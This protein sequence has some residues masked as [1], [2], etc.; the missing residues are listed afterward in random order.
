MEVSLCHP[1]IA[2]FAGRLVL[3]GGIDYL[4]HSPRANQAV[5]MLPLKEGRVVSKQVSFGDV[6]RE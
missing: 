5:L 4:S 3:I 2:I 1:D 6:S